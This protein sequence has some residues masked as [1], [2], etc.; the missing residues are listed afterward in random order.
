MEESSCYLKELLTAMRR[1]ALR[2]NQVSKPRVKVTL[3][4]K[5]TFVLSKTSM[6]IKGF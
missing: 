6:Y 2:M 4:K 3:L 5:K 1:T